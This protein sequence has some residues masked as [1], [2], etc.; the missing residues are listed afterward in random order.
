MGP[1]PQI[2]SFLMLALLDL[3]LDRLRN[4]PR[5]RSFTWMLAPFFILWANL[6]GGFIWGFLLLGA[7]MAGETQERITGL[8]R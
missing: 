1:R 6:H 7:F 4:E 5:L 8:E 3:G 2:L